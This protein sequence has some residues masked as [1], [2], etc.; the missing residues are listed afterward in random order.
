MNCKVYFKVPFLLLM[1]IAIISCSNKKSGDF[2]KAITDKQSESFNMLLGEKGWESRR[3]DYIIKNDYAKALYAVDEQEKG[4]DKIIQDL[5]ALNTENI[6]KGSEVQK[7]A[8]A[9]YS[10]L[11][12]LFLFSRNEIIEQEKSMNSQDDKEVD[13]AQ[14]QLLKI[15]IEK[16]KMYQEVYKNDEILFRTLKEFDRENGL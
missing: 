13:D 1:F 8:V 15:S 2:K 11:K 7:A 14:R 4:F 10:S 9:Y 16:Q 5:K 12:K 3:L 6:A